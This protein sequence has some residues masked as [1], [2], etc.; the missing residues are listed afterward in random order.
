MSFDPR[1]PVLVGI[2]T[3]MQ[4]EDLLA[5][6][7][8]PMDL[9]LQAVRRAGID[10]AGAN[11]GDVRALSSVQTIAVP[12]GRWRYRNPA[13]EIARHIGAKAATTVL[14]SVGVLQ[15]SLIGDACDRIAKGDMDCALIVGA[16]AGHR[17]LCAKKTVNGRGSVSRT[18]RPMCLSNPKKSFFIRLNYTQA[19]ACQ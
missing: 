14:A 3:C 9:M 12:K 7:K 10:A 15:Q 4:R 17:I 16:D 11:G 13:G 1:Q 19:C 18:T 5:R 8:E 6:S 2:G